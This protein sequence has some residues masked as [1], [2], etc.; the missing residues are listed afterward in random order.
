MYCG[1][2]GKIHEYIA[3]FIFYEKALFDAPFFYWKKI[4]KRLYIALLFME[5]GKISNEKNGGRK[6]FK[7]FPI[8]EKTPII[9][10]K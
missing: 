7:F 10:Q 3:Y 8:P 6:I 4:K 5:L 9:W 1:H 2:A